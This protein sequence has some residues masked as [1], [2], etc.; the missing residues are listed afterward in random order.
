M[1]F[2]LDVHGMVVM[3]ESMLQPVSPSIISLNRML[4]IGVAVKVRYNFPLS[5]IIPSLYSFLHL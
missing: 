3:N 4:D 1:L 2:V 5:I